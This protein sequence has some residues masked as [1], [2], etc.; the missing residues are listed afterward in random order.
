MSPEKCGMTFPNNAWEH[1]ESAPEICRNGNESTF[2]QN[3]GN[4]FSRHQYN[5][6]F[7][8]IK[9][10]Q[11]LTYTSNHKH[12]IY[13]KPQASHI[14]QTTSFTYTYTSNHKLHIHI[15]IKP[16]ASY[17]HIHQTT[18]FSFIK[19]GKMEEMGDINGRKELGRR[20]TN[21]NMKQSRFEA[22]YGSI[23][24]RNKVG[25][26]RKPRWGRSRSRVKCVE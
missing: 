10:Q 4:S 8:Y 17:T 22:K 26:R 18:S 14:H 6:R 15:Y 3:I 9:P 12:H 1:V 13:I 20:S 23:N 7:T 5:T 21:I 2:Q 19:G 25:R 11:S 16:Q 24:G